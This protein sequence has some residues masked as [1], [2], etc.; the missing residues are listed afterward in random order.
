ME[1]CIGFDELCPTVREV[2][3]QLNDFWQIPRRIYDYQFMY[4]LSGH[5]LL[6]IDKQKRRL[7]RGQLAIIP[8]NVKHTLV[9]EENQSAEI[10]WMHLDLISQDD[11]DWVYRFYSTPDAYVL[12]FGDRLPFPEHIRKQ[13]VFPGGFRLPRFVTFDEPIEIE[14]LFRSVLKA[15][16]A[17]IGYF[18]L[19]S[20]TVVLQLMD[21]IFSQ[22]GYWQSSGKP[23]LVSDVMKQYI[24]SNYMRKITLQDIGKCTRYN[25]DYA[26]KLF[27]KETG[28]TVVEYINHYRISKAK[29]MLLDPS[30]PMTEI[31]ARCGFQTVNYFSSVCRDLT[32][33]SPRALRA[34]Y[35][36]I[37]DQGPIY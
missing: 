2:G 9:Y 35:L 37:M 12:L 13:L 10:V 21:A 16:M 24:R 19:I 3:M 27:R 15:Y 25:P 4:C 33:K 30:L 34:H 23:I 28:K 29:A 11:G 6:T 20:R 7:Q 8:P 17:E 26:G 1:K 31:A 22:C 18:Q 14:R 5:A 32:G 36:T